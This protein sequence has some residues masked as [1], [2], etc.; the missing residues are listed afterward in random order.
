MQPC[1]SQQIQILISQPL[2]LH[3][4]SLSVPFQ[5]MQSVHCASEAHLASRGSV[6][7]GLLSVVSKAAN[8]ELLCHCHSVSQQWFFN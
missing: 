6:Y 7:P 8:A 1:N 5:K 3:I 4:L 2:V